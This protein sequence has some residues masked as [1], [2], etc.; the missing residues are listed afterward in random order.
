MNKSYARRTSDLLAARER[1]SQLEAELDDAWK[2]AERIAKEVDDFTNGDFDTEEAV[3]GTAEKVSVPNSPSPLTPKIGAL[4]QVEPIPVFSPLSPVPLPRFAC[5]P[6]TEKGEDV[7]S[8]LHTTHTQ[9]EAPPQ[10][11][12]PPIPPQSQP[13]NPPKDTTDTASIRSTK[14]TRSIKS[15]HS[16]NPDE[17]PTSQ[18][19]LVTA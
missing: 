8:D 11:Q 3:I 17:S 13:Q 4:L 12:N 9:H 15:I 14:S 1:I 18:L 16:K 7:C 5:T 2:E 6:V 19:H 10:V